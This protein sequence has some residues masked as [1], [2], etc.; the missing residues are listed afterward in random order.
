[1]AKTFLV[2]L[3]S[4][5][6]IFPALS[7]TDPPPDYSKEAAIIQNMATKVAF[8]EDGSREWQLTVSVRLQ[9][10]SGVRQFGVLSF[11]YR[12]ENETIN[13][14]YMRVRK[15]DGSIVETPGSSVLDVT[16]EVAKIAPTY[17]DLH[18][19]QIPVKALGVGDILEYSIRSSQ[20]NIE[21]PGQFYYD[22]TFF[23]DSVILNQ[24]L[25]ISVPKQKY[26]QVFSPKL[27]PET[28]EDSD[29]RIYL[30]KFSQLSLSKPKDQKKANTEE[31]EPPVVRI[32]SFKNWEEVGNWW[33]SLASSQSQRAHKWLIF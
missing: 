22:Q 26:L 24:T 23:N 20:K 17:S 16:T 14:D 10:E 8:S 19:K 27:H 3:V 11:P 2:R 12:S 18:E 33:S 9:T 28:R 4:L 21:M 13:I 7:F 25:E 30:W 32:T 15:S 1:V 29:R 6:I 31:D 5:L